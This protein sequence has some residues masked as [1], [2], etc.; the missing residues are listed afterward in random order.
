M[1]QTHFFG[2]FAATLLVSA[3]VA[4]PPPMPYNWWQAWTTLSTNFI[5]EEGNA[6]E[7]SSFGFHSVVNQNQEVLC[8]HGILELFP[9][10]QNYSVTDVTNFTAGYRHHRYMNDNGT[11]T[12][13]TSSKVAGKMQAGGAY[14]LAPRPDIFA[15]MTFLENTTANGQNCS[16]WMWQGFDDN[17]NR[18]LVQ[19]FVSWEDDD[20]Q[21]LVNQTWYVD[22]KTKKT[23]SIIHTTAFNG[24]EEMNY[25]PIQC[26]EPNICGEE[27][28]A[29]NAGAG[30]G[31][32]Q[33]AI[34][35][36]CGGYVDCT[37]ISIGGPNY[38]PDTV[39]SHASWVFNQYFQA[40]AGQGASACDFN[41][42]GL[43]TI[44]GTNCTTCNMTAS[45]NEQQAISAIGWICSKAHIDCSPILPGG[46]NFLPNTTQNH[47][48]W[49]YNVYYQAYKCVPGN[50]WCYFNN[51][52]AIV[53]C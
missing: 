27:Y 13:C 17:G 33:S 46:S 50:D 4:I 31:A 30:D 5:N 51:T 2:I 23:S 38:Y 39:L 24:Y 9:V 32:L 1:R 48:N 22:P 34:N 44:C 52:A 40:N 8:R 36:A 6:S 28:C 10:V 14:Y 16:L 12:N 35:W 20:T 53:N 45:A 29:A 15:Q 37:N 21:I 26:S 3:C 11:V 41:G 43:L 7:V 49:A 47:A 18:N 42:A 19:W 25:W